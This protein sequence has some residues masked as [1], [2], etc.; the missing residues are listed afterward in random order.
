MSNNC[1]VCWSITGPFVSTFNEV[2]NIG[3]TEVWK[4]GLH[5]QIVHNFLRVYVI[6][7][8]YNILLNR[9]YTKDVMILNVN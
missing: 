1:T 8:N 7:I 5:M 4:V 3:K 6:H 2:F 9:T